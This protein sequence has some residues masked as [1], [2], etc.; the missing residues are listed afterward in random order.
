MGTNV[1]NKIVI[2]VII[3]VIIGIGVT[4]SS[5]SMESTEEIIQIENERVLDETVPVVGETTPVE[6]KKTGRSL[7]VELT[8]SI[9]LKTP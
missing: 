6:E 7:S 4:A 3:A 2:I 9:G 5:I 8:E 1:M